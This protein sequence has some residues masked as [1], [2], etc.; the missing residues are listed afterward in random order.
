MGAFEPEKRESAK[1]L[2]KMME[3]DGKE[4]LLTMLEQAKNV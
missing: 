3:F 4:E 2:L 1:I